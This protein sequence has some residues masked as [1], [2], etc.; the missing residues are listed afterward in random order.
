MATDAKAYEVLI[1]EVTVHQDV[2]QLLHP[3]TGEQTGFQLGNGKTWFEGEKIP[4]DQVGSMYKEALADSSNP[5]YESLSKKLRPVSEAS[6]SDA[7]SEP[8]PGY[9]EMD[10]NEVVQAMRV[11]PSAT[12]QRIKDYESA[13][14]EP[15][16]A[17]TSYNIGYGEHPD[18]R[19]MTEL[20]VNEDEM[21]DN[22]AVRRLKTRHV[23]EDGPV[24]HGEG[25]T[26]TGE[27]QKGYGEEEDGEKGDVKGGPK[28]ARRGRRDRQPKPT[29]G[30]TKDEGGSSLGKVNED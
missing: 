19:Q 8:F 25:I 5:L 13:K 14:D 21:D 6:E 2:R 17:I 10:D 1:E 12:I 30:V 3:I 28:R 29:P 16:D 9:N 20:E 7:M 27:P 24:E 4:A 18:T 15:R 23:P 26:G 11:L 22:K